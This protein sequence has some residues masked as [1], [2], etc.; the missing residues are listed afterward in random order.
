MKHELIWKQQL[1]S[2]LRDDYFGKNVEWEFKDVCKYISK[3]EKLGASYIQI[4]DNESIEFQ[5]PA[6]LNCADLLMFILTSDTRP[7]TVL[8]KKGKYNNKLFLEWR[9]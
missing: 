1:K 8:H 7:S 6:Q 5:L 2:I 9:Y 4:V 3:L